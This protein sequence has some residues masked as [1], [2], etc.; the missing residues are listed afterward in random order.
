MLPEVRPTPPR[1]RGLAGL[2]RSLGILILLLVVFGLGYQIG[3]SFRGL[4]EPEIQVVVDR[5]YYPTVKTLLA[6][7]QDRID[8]LMF[9]LFDYEKEDAMDTLY[10]LLIDAHNRGVEVRVLTE[11]GEAYLGES[12]L[13]KSDRALQKLQAAGIEVRVDPPKITTHVKLCIVDD[14]V[15]IGS[16]NWNYYALFRNHEA[17]LRVRDPRVVRD[18][19]RYFNRLWKEAKPYPGPGKREVSMH[20]QATDSP[21]A[22]ILKNKAL[23]DG[24]KVLLRGHVEN[25]QFRFSQR[26]TPYTL[27]RLRDQAASIRVFTRDH[28]Q[29]QEG[30]S[31]QVAGVYYKS[32]KVGRFT[33]HNEVEAEEI[34]VLQGGE[35]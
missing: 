8:L 35:P 31:V 17:N 33:Y 3:R 28:P 5:D 34:A 26:G 21:I 22:R 15:L 30:D 18:L 25:L 16:T 9:E 7:A 2:P 29:I 1:P 11:G 12:F 27:F 13:E 19:E 23:Y 14:Q 10:Q 24:R 4:H 32:R 6:Q 20:T